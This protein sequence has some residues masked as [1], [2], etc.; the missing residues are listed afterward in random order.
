MSSIQDAVDLLQTV[1]AGGVPAFITN[2][3]RQT[4]EANG[5]EV[6]DSMTPNDVIASLRQQV[7]S[8][9]LDR[10]VR[11]QEMVQSGHI[12]KS[13]EMEARIARVRQA[14]DTGDM[15]GG[16]QEM[17]AILSGPKAAAPVPKEERPKLVPDPS[18]KEEKPAKPI[19]TSRLDALFDKLD[20]EL[21]AVEQAIESEPA[22]QNDDR[23]PS[24]DSFAGQEVAA[25]KQDS[26]E[27]SN[28]E[29]PNAA[30]A[31]AVVADIATTVTAPT[32]MQAAPATTEPDRTESHSIEPTYDKDAAAASYQ[33]GLQK[34]AARHGSKKTPDEPRFAPRDY[35]V[36]PEQAQDRK[37]KEL[38]QQAKQLVQKDLQAIATEE[39]AASR[40]G[41]T[42][43]FPPRLAEVAAW[44]RTQQG[45]PPLPKEQAEFFNRQYAEITGQQTEYF[46]SQRYGPRDIES[47]ASP[48][49]SSPP[50]S[51]QQA[52]PSSA[53]GNSSETP[54]SSS[55]Q[56][57]SPE[58][59]DNSPE[60]SAEAP[61]GSQAAPSMGGDDGYVDPVQKLKAEFGAKFGE[62][63]ENL[64]KL[65]GHDPERMEKFGQEAAHGMDVQSPG[66][67]DV[68]SGKAHLDWQT[69][70]YEFKRTSAKPA[71]RWDEAQKGRQSAPSIRD[72]ERGEGVAW[73]SSGSSGSAG[74]GSS[75][76]RDVV[77]LLKEIRDLLK[78][79]DGKKDQQPTAA[80]NGS[81]FLAAL[82]PKPAMVPNTVPAIKG[83]AK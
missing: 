59:P 16:I 50:P 15:A 19:D 67:W 34:M 52:A 9:F 76:D 38:V 36:P 68:M 12:A 43:K 22:E 40:G 5:V 20:A 81:G 57:S 83:V 31:P 28:T 51:G 44:N 14:D 39:I 79:K 69:Q 30:A 17:D 56:G 53:G 73:S 27:R 77:N 24:S 65:P 75:F 25:E 1:D 60:A 35:G 82:P 29:Q 10:W 21:T 42:A 61:S 8:A 3:L 66:L 33:A 58:I 72:G 62:M 48:Q 54:N 7:E 11:V 4:A 71:K 46:P 70:E 63:D 37:V 45:P 78:S 55:E 74:G 41:Y 6:S 13:E 49:V 64:A 47:K 18:P 26:A 2:K 23:T 32:S 80:G